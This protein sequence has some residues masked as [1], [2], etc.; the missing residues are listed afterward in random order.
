MPCYDRYKQRWQIVKEE[1]NRQRQKGEA[2]NYG[3]K[4]RYRRSVEELYA[5]LKESLDSHEKERERL[6]K[7]LKDPNLTEAEREEILRE[8]DELDRE[9]AGMRDMLEELLEFMR[10]LERRTISTPKQGT[11]E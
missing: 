7:R 5:K 11:N 3:Q 1:I 6:I 9:L 4:E 2:P 10:D 8:L